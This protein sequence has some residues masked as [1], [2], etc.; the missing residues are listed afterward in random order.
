MPIRASELLSVNGVGQRKLER[1]GAP[2]MAMIR[3]H[4]DGDDE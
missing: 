1:F 3:A 2:F 4:L